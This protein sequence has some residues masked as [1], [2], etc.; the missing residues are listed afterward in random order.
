MKK[1]KVIHLLQSNKFSGAENVVC[2]IIELF[3]GDNRYEMI[4]VCTAG[5]IESVLK[6][7]NIQ[8]FFLEKFTLKNISKAIQILKPDIIQAHDFTASIYAAKYGKTINI[9]SHIHQ[10]PLWLSSKVN[11]KSII[12][13]ICSRRYRKIIGTSNSILTEFCYKK[14]IS[15]KFELLPNVIDTDKIKEMS[16][17]GDD[18]QE[19]SYDLLYVGRMSSPKNPIGFLKILKRLR[20]F[21]EVKA[22]MVGDGPLFEEVQRYIDENDLKETV[23]L[24]GFERNPYIFMKA[25]KLLLMPSLWE[26]FGL[27]AVEAMSLGTPVVCYNVG[28]LKDIV[29]S[30]CGFRCKDEDSMVDF[31]FKFYQNPQIRYSLSESAKEKAKLYV[32]LEKY[33]QQLISYYECCD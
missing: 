7:K 25:A 30:S 28:G 9:I 5:E 21:F 12:Y 16:M 18:M 31:L 14:Y 8:Y 1:I 20:C 27:V 29:D 22:V 11:I 6:E 17:I 19:L 26:G 4:Y 23:E 2:Q 10:N 33:K 13:A 15:N 3:K 32:N 24:R